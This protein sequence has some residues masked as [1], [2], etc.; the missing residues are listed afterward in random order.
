MGKKAETKEYVGLTSQWVLERSIVFGWVIT[1][2]QEQLNDLNAV[3]HVEMLVNDRGSKKKFL[4]FEVDAESRETSTSIPF[5]AVAD[6][7]RKHGYVVEKP[8]RIRR[9]RLYRDADDSVQ[10]KKLRRRR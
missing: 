7:L 10:G 9:T 8:K 5:D 6:L 1:N 3:V 2:S 4:T